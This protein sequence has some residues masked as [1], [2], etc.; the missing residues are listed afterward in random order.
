MGFGVKQGMVFTSYLS[1]PQL[2]SKLNDPKNYLFWSKLEQKKKNAGR[3]R[4]IFLAKIKIKE[5]CTKNLLWTL[6][7]PGEK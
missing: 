2:K 3:R 1:F 6:D 7:Y 4:S 5:N